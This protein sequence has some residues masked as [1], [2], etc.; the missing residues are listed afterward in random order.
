VAHLAFGKYIPGQIPGDVED[1]ARVLG[2]E[3]RRIEIALNLPVWQAQIM[4]TLVAQPNVYYDGMVV[5]ADGVGW[6]PGNGAGLLLATHSSGQ[7]IHPLVQCGLLQFG[8]LQ[9]QVGQ[10]DVLGCIIPVP[11][12]FQ[13][14]PSIFPT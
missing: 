4:D 12:L 2:D 5:S 13:K 9:S 3:L 11:A 8:S 6:D 1:V 7:S 14:L 10:Q